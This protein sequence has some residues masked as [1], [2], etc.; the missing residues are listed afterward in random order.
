MRGWDLDFFRGNWLE[1][2]FVQQMIAMHD[3]A[4]AEVS[5]SLVKWK[6][7]PTAEDAKAFKTEQKS[8][9]VYWSEATHPREDGSVFLGYSDVTQILWDC[10]NKVSKDL[11]LKVPLAIEFVFGMNW[12][13][14]H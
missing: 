1:N 10:V 8:L 6:K 14:R 11:K 13:D 7:F 5:K 9:G 2:D 12:R 3:E 4:Q